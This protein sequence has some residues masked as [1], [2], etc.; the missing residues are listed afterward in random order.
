MLCLGKNTLGERGADFMFALTRSTGGWY[1]GL[2]D[3]YDFELARSKYAD[4]N[5]L[6]DTW[7]GGYVPNAA[8]VYVPKA[9]NELALTDLGLLTQPTR[10]NKNTSRNANPTDLTGVTK[11]GDAAAVLSVVDDTAALTAAGLSGICT[12][13]KV[14]KL[15]NSAGTTNAQAGLSPATGNT[16]VHAISAFMRGSGTANLRLF[17]NPIPPTFTLPSDYER[18]TNIVTPTV[19]Q[20]VAVE[21][22]PGSIVYFILN[23]LEEGSFATEPIITTGSAVT[24]TGNRPVEDLT[25]KLNYG[26]AGFVKVDVRD[27][28]QIRSRVIRFYNAAEEYFELRRDENAF[29]WLVMSGGVVQSQSVAATSA[30]KGL[31]TLAF[32]AGPNFSK[33]RFIGGIDTAADLTV[34]WPLLSKVAIGGYG[35]S[36]SANSYQFTKKLGLIFGTPSRP[37]NQA[38]FDQVYAQAVAA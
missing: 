38:L 4:Y 17:A 7:S 30:I 16:N 36:T 3:W 21:A 23:Q 20:A 18:Y 2:D 13:G 14:Y 6:T 24:R 19:S 8:G 9:A 26:V 5:G 15:D 10:T 22:L 1:S 37:I 29:Q 32:A 33:A 25:G 35:S 27:Y 31:L 11:A 28:E 34:S 12:S